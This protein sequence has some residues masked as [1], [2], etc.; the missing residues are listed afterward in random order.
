MPSLCFILVTTSSFRSASDL[1]PV[2]LGFHLSGGPWKIHGSFKI[3][4]LVILLAGLITRHRLMMLLNKTDKD[5]R[6]EK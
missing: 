4:L 6:F 2:V 3:P 5:D 1:R